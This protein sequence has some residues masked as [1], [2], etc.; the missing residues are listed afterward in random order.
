MLCVSPDLLSK[1]SAACF[2]SE[3]DVSCVI[4]NYTF[5]VGT[6]ACYIVNFASGYAVGINTWFH[7]S[8]MTLHFLA[9]GPSI[10]KGLEQC[11]LRGRL[12]L[13]DG[14][15]WRAGPWHWNCSSWHARKPQNSEGEITEKRSTFDVVDAV[16]VSVVWWWV[17]RLMC[18]FCMLFS[19]WLLYIQS[20][21]LF[22]VSAWAGENDI[23][24][25]A[26]KADIYLFVP[27]WQ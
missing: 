14:S 13:P 4:F 18:L 11:T 23:T 21:F 10:D 19:V 16:T 17:H 20:S 22:S 6:S 12:W 26:W 1:L 9:A 15:D 25:A 7:F 3:T 8:W 5:C 24:E 27:V 2:F